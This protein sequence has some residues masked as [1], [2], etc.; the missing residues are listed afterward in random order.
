MNEL[1]IQDLIKMLNGKGNSSIQ[2]L[3]KAIGE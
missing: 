3:V 1:K 2:A